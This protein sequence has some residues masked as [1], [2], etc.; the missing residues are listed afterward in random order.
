MQGVK[1]AVD[2]RMIADPARHRQISA[3]QGRQALQ[4]V[5]QIEGPIAQRLGKTEHLGGFLHRHPS[6]WRKMAAQQG[7]SFGMGLPLRALKG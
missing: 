2:H 4:G 1:L 7:Q 3:Q 5:T 6:V